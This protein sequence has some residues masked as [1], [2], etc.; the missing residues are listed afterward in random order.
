MNSRIARYCRRNDIEFV[1]TFDLMLGP[2]GLPR[3][4]IYVADRLH[5]NAK[6]YAIWAE[7]VRPH[8][9]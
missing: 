3:P 8:L 7:A 9:Q 5:M 4:D 1:N 6:G 2:D